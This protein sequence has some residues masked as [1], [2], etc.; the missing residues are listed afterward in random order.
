MT[1]K[2]VSS[3][4]VRDRGLLRLSALVYPSNPWLRPIRHL[5]KDHLLISLP[6]LSTAFGTWLGGHWLLLKLTA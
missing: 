3:R 5:K 4:K 2:G 6:L 1:R